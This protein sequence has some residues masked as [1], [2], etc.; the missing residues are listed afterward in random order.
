MVPH[1]EFSNWQIKLSYLY[2]IS[3]AFV[4]YEGVRFLQFTLRSYFD[5][6]NKPL[7]KIL[8][9]I[10]T[11]PFYVVPMS[12]L[13]LV[14]WYKIFMN[15][16]VD[17]HVVRLS[18]IIILI[19]VFFLVNLYE[20]VFLVRDVAN[21]KLQ[22][23]QLERA[24]AEAELEALKNQIDPHFIFNSLNTLSHLIEEK[25][26]KAKLFNDHMA[27][28]YR[29]ILQN[30]AKDLVLLRDEMLFMQD[31]FSL[32]KI[33]F[34]D[35]LQLQTEVDETL[36]DRYLIPPI[37][38]QVLLENAVKHNEFSETSPLQIQLV[39]V[40][41]ELQMR[42]KLKEKKLRKPSSRIGLQNLEERYRLSTDRSICIERSDD[43]FIVCLPILKID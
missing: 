37:S 35:A 39:F 9:F 6:L 26:E 24:K 13:M 42:N 33:R 12:I 7:K 43:M 18:S 8:A 17:W 16:I 36:W 41:N 14:G 27:D 28:V 1:E 30:K 4:I 22:Q 2:T 15:G 11:I 21:D 19:A 40:G 32:L 20:T 5:W 23:E 29:Y 25:P 31:Y 38:L 34:E 3:I 10:I